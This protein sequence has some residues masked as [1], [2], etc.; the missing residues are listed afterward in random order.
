M[1]RIIIII[2]L[3]LCMMFVEYRFIM[4]HL[5]PYRGENGTVY[6]EC[7]GVVDTY[8]AEPATELWP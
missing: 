8:Y 3:I 7:F 2:L 4:H 6:I 5:C 1:K